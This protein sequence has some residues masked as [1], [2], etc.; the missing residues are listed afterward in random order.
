[1]EMMKDY[2]DSYLKCHISLL[3]DV[4]DKFTNTILSNY[5][6]C[7]SQYLNAPALSWNSMINMSKDELEKTFI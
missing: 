5:R 2:H 3:H 7:P 1:M 6:L 4:S